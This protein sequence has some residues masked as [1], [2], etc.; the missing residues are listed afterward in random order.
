[1]QTKTI[2][3]DGESQSACNYYELRDKCPKCGKKWVFIK[4]D[5]YLIQVCTNCDAKLEQSGMQ[6]P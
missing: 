5:D 1:M 6:E 3:S 2:S 4:H